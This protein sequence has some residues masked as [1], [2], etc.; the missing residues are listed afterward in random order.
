MH[1]YSID[2]G[3]P[4]GLSVASIGTVVIFVVLLLL[5]FISWLRVKFPSKRAARK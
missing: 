2:S 5:A 1:T 3:R 4:P